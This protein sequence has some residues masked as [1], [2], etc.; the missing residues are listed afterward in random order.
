MKKLFL[1]ALIATTF[2]VNAQKQKILI[3][4]PSKEIGIR[5]NEM[6]FN[7][8]I[9]FVFKKQMKYNPNKYMRYRIALNEN[10]FLGN[11]KPCACGNVNFNYAL[12]IGQENR[13]NFTNK[14]RFIHGAE[15]SIKTAGAFNLNNLGNKP[16]TSFN[17]NSQLGYFLGF[18]FQPNK[19]LIFTIEHIP[20]AIGYDFHSYVYYNPISEQKARGWNQEFHPVFGFKPKFTV[21][22]KF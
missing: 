9:D 10:M 16:F 1:I 6:R 17:V 15:L 4:N 22:Y 3:E 2:S 14:F 7:S 8:N 20:T 5:F 21:T 12:A 18:Q 19:N 13:V 11:I